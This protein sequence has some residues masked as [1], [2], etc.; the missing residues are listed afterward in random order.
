MEPACSVVI[1]PN[2]IYPRNIMIIEE[3]MQKLEQQSLV[4]RL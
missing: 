3:F 4:V 1:V 2:Q